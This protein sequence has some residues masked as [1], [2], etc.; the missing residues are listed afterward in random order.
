MTASRPASSGAASYFSRSRRRKAPRRLSSCAQAQAEA[1]A[2]KPAAQGREVGRRVR[3]ARDAQAVYV[4][5]RALGQAEALKLGGVHLQPLVAP[6]ADGREAELHAAALHVGDDDALFSRLVEA[7]ALGAA[8][9]GVEA[10]P[11]PAQAAEGVDVAEGG[12]VE[13]AGGQLLL[14]NG[15]VARGG[16]AHLAVQAEQLEPPLLPGRGKAAQQ[17]A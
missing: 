13:A 14:G 11:R 8:G 2:L 6:G 12:V 9:P 5:L 7:A 17:G 1:L 15:V 10:V 4:P 3:L 16:D